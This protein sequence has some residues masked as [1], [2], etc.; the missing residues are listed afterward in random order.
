M[1]VSLRGPQ[2]PQSKLSPTIVVS[3][4]VITAVIGGI[5]GALVTLLIR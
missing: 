1:P 5:L 2:Y 3:L 4:I